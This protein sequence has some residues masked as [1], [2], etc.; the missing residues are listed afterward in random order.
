MNTWDGWVS[1][2]FFHFSCLGFFGNEN[3]KGD[4]INMGGGCGWQRQYNKVLKKKK[5][6]K[7]S[8]GA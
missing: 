3:I 6:K 4:L 5:K 7:C 1:L 2:R 8:V